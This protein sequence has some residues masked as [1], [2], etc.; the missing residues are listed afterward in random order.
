[1][2]TKG[3]VPQAVSREG[4]CQER[5]SEDASIATVAGAE[6]VCQLPNVEI[7][8]GGFVG[9]FHRVQNQLACAS[10]SCSSDD[11]IPRQCLSIKIR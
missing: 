1:M 5:L 7:A 11:T 2:Q 6:E 3:N 4:I 8:I 9:A 10:A